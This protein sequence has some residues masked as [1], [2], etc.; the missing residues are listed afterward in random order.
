M[1]V[2]DESPARERLRGM[3]AAFDDVEVVGEAEDGEEATRSIPAAR[4]DIVFL[5]IE[6]PGRTGLEVAAAL[7]PPRPRIVFCTA[8]D[9]YAIAAFEQH[10][11]DYLLKPLRQER[12][13]RSL[14]SVRAAL[15]EE[16]RR[17]READEARE[18]QAH[19]FPCSPPR[20]ETLD[21]AGRCRPAREVGGDY[22]D[23][24]PLGP[25]AL[26]IAVGDV[27]GKGL[28]AGLLMASLQARLQGA[29]VAR[30]RAVGPAL[31]DVNEILHATTASRHYVTLLYGVY[32]AA[33]RELTYAN[34]GHPPLLVFRPGEPPQRLVAQGPPLGAFTET[35][36]PAST[37]SLS[38]GD[39]LV[40]F[41]DGVTE[42]ADPSGAE[43]GEG[44]IQAVVEAHLALDAAG[45]R[46]RIFLEL[47]GFCDHRAQEDDQTIVVAKV[48]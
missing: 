22:Y 29:A 1:L 15:V 37:V 36:Y 2:D 5:D 25:L 23:F 9:Q 17:R 41:T 44:R 26:G 16:G 39:V 18:V 12:L 11:V 19:L 28:F 33:T 47:D 27:S 4:P 14:E 20:L 40:G 42:A 45:L 48:R 10:A 32:D 38:E 7:P 34:A 43:F 24:L 46:D 35:E 3:L 13:A 30:G 31:S 8:Y 6:M 21:Y